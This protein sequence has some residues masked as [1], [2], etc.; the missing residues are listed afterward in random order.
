MRALRLIHKWIG[1]AV[2]LFFFTSCL[3]AFV[4]LIGKISVE[5]SHAPLIGFMKRMHTSLF[6][7]D[8]GKIIL[9][10][11]TLLA[12][13][14]IIT[15]YFLWW[16]IAKGRI[17]VAVKKGRTRLAGLRDSLSLTKPTKRL[18]WHV[19]AG[20]WSGIPLLIIIG[21]ALTWS[22][23]WYAKIFYGVF[24]ANDNMFHTVHD[25][26]VGTWL[27]MWSRWLW[28]IV[29]AFAL[30]VVITGIIIFIKKYQATHT[31]QFQKND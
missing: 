3:T 8:A 31:A 20:F 16:K 15:G 12:A 9:G 18:A 2:A 7:G 26:H 13:V 6:L 27:G 1:L 29:M 4:Y 11:V 23:G 22:F 14:E 25:I 28:L 21:T 17:K 30:I 5:Y 24:G 19:T 10:I